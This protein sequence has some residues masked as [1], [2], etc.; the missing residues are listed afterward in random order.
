VPVHGRAAVT[1]LPLQDRVIHGALPGSAWVWLWELAIIGTIDEL[2]DAEE[3][4]TYQQPRWSSE[5]EKL[6][7][8]VRWGMIISM[9]R[10]AVRQGAP[11]TFDQVI[12]DND[13]L[14]TEL[15]RRIDF[16][17]TPERDRLVKEMVIDVQLRW[18]GARDRLYNEIRKD[19]GLDT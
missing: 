11:A 13:Q 14:Q 5:Q 16:T 2:D 19:L 9:L 10:E 3:K 8:F 1:P 7:L 17:L 6:E 4:E 18:P 15:F 12:A